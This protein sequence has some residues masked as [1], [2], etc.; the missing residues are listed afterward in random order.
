MV[1]QAMGNYVHEGR[2]RSD[3]QEPGFTGRRLPSPARQDCRLRQQ[4]ASGYEAKKTQ[5]RGEVKQDIVRVVKVRLLPGGREY[6]SAA[7]LIEKVIQPDAKPGVVEKH[8]NA[9]AP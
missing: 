8:I 1:N 4:P 2:G 7:I 5:P 9:G 3:N 6:V